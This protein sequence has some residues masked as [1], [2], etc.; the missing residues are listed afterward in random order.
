MAS[1][2][3]NR[4]PRVAAVAMMLAVS[5]TCADPAS[6]PNGSA[7]GNVLIGADSVATKDATTPP[8][9][10]AIDDPSIGVGDTTRAR[11]TL[12]RDRLRDLQRDG[13]N[14][15]W[16]S[17]DTTVARVIRL[18]G[19]VMGVA[20]GSASITAS[21]GGK[22]GSA[23]VTVSGWQAP[24][25]S[26]AV[27]LRASA[28]RVGDTTRATAT[29]R[30]ANNN[31]LTGRVVSWRSDNPAVASVNAS[32]LVTAAAVG[33]TA[34][35]GTSEGVSGRATITVSTAPPPPPPPANGVADP[36]LLPRATGQRPVA[37]TYG[38]SLA[39]GQKY[40][41]PLTGV[42]VLKL[43]SASVPSSNGGAY[44]GYSEGGPIISQPWAG[45][46][47]NT[48]YTA[49]LA[50]GWLVDI[51]Y[52]TF[53]SSNWRRAPV[54]GE[55]KWA[56]SLNASTPRIAYYVDNGN[57][58]TIH[59]YNTATNQ[60]QDTGIFPYTTSASGSSLTWLQVNLNDQWL[61][62]MFNGN[63]TVMAVRI[64]DGLTRT[65]TT[66]FAGGIDIDEPHLDREFPV[67]YISTNDEQTLIVNLETGTVVSEN[68]PAGVDA[69]DHAAPM[70]GKIVAVSWE[71]NGIIVVE[72]QGAIRVA[73]T[74]S[75]TDWS[76]DW[77]MAA[78]WVLNNPSQY[79][80]V[81]QWAKASNFPIS[82]GMIGFVSLAGDMRIIAAH[83]ATG[84][85]YENGGQPHPTLS[86]D[87]KLVMWT[88]NMNGSS[89]H[90]VFMARI[91]TR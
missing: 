25:A 21:I 86:P 84:T 10:V 42:S 31:V 88:S 70:R 14:I 61:V 50:D 8:I 54:D 55:I 16:K 80:V 29:T 71:A 66:S 51:R 24:V 45:T 78:Q 74:P 46:D 63:S 4:V 13:R 35:V 56:F 81:D 69:A 32:G 43:T 79:F 38:R 62:G 36:T 33:T 41:D 18:T 52:D 60:N 22:S 48:Y 53:A 82:R 23:T 72:R 91:P 2:Y 6:P 9:S 73:V 26:V 49:Y 67:V 64:S 39:A 58:K 30:D 1:S 5:I 19:Y 44:H 27:A 57:D 59:R 11:A 28:V 76:G 17:S 7:D 47:G 12:N 83:D 40:N 90:D 34:I 20:A 75:P 68:D 89:R 87:G 85:G 3:F 77:H 37:G 65:F 15:I